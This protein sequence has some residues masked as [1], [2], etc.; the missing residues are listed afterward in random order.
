MNMALE[1]PDQP[2][3]QGTRLR[4]GFERRGPFGQDTNDPLSVFMQERLAEWLDSTSD[5]PR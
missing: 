3:A 2:E 5:G 1:S 4:R